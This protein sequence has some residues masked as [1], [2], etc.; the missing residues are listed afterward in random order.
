MPVLGRS[1][2]LDGQAS[3]LAPLRNLE[4]TIFQNAVRDLEKIKSFGHDEVELADRPPATQVQLTELTKCTT[5]RSKS[6][7]PDG[8]NRIR[9]AMIATG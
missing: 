2:P 1:R 9:A 5:V 7:L 4:P 6:C 3:E 8:N